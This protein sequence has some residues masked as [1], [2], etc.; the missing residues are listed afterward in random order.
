MLF[1]RL[2]GATAVCLGRVGNRLFGARRMATAYLWKPGHTNTILPGA[3]DHLIAGR[4]VPTPVILLRGAA[5]L[6]RHR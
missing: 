2:A 4:F 3:L 5:L 6:G 1:N